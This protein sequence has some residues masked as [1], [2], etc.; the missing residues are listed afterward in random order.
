MT[1]ELTA[2]YV[3]NV[4]QKCKKRRKIVSGLLTILTTSKTV[5]VSWLFLS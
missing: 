1:I 2:K 4:E 3:C 5:I